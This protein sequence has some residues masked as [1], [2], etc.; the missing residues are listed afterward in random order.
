MKFM[1][2]KWVYRN[3]GGIDRGDVTSRNWLYVLGLV[4]DEIHYGLW[5]I[6]RRDNP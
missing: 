5:K 2:L 4:V 6:M 3:S 1:V